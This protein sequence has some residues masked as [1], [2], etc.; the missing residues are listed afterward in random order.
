MGKIAFADRLAAA[1]KNRQKEF[2]VAGATLTLCTWNYDQNL[3][4][5]AMVAEF[6]KTFLSNSKREALKEI[7][8][9][10]V[11]EWFQ[12]NGK[13]LKAIIS[14]SVLEENFDSLDEAAQWTNELDLEAMMLLTQEIFK[15]NAGPLAKRLG[16][17]TEFLAEAVQNTNGVSGQLP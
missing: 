3:K 15:R 7:L 17:S 16:L 4:F 14:E 11:G 5:G 9:G 10:D 6:A 12:R 8:K 13:A 2:F 1:R